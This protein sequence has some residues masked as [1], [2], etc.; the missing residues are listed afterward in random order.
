VVCGRFLNIQTSK[1]RGKKLG[2]GPSPAAGA[3]SH[4]TTGRM[5]NP[6]LWVMGGQVDAEGVRPSNRRL[7]ESS[8]VMSSLKTLF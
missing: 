6:A 1:Q 7:W 3:P 5:V 8:D 2:V 4:C